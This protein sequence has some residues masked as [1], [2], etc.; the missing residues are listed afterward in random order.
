MFEIISAIKTNDINSVHQNVSSYMSAYNIKGLVWQKRHMWLRTVRSIEITIAGKK[1]RLDMILTCRTYFAY[2]NA[3]DC[4]ICDD[5]S[6]S[7]CTDPDELKRSLIR[8]ED[9][10]LPGIWNTNKIL[11]AVNPYCVISDI[12]YWYNL[13]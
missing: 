11:S 5:F 9:R 8:Q 6:F 4:K 3:I 2:F 1:I 13:S 10:L 7:N 12:E